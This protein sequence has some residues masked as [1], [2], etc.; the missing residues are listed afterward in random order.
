MNNHP[1]SRPAL[2]LPDAVSLVVGI[3]I[4]SGIYLTPAG[5]FANVASAGAGLLVWLAGGVV[6]LVGALCYAELATAYPTASGEYAYLRRAYGPFVGFSFAWAQLAVIRTGASLAPV[7]YVFAT[8]AQQLYDLGPNSKLIYVTAAIVGLTLVNAL[9]IHPGRRTQNL[10]TL[11]KLMGLCGLVLAGLWLYVRP[12]RMVLIEQ[13]PPAANT[14]LTLA[15]VLVLWTYSGWHEVAYVVMDLRDRSR[16]LTRAIL[17]GVAAVT[18]VYLA[19]NLAL[20]AGLGFTGVRE[21]KAVASDLLERAL[22]PPGKA[23]MAWLVVI[24]TLGATNGLILAGGR[25]FAGFGELHPGFGWLGAGRTNR[26]APLVAL[27][28]QAAVSLGMVALV[29]CGDAWR[30]WVAE[31]AQR[32][33]VE[34]PLDLTAPTDG[35][36]T[37]V[38]CTG[39]VFWFFLLLTGGALLVLRV[40]DAD[41]PRPFRV[42]LFPVVSVLF[43]GA[44]LFMLYQSGAYAASQRPAEALVVA[45]LFVLGLP[46]YALTRRGSDGEG[47]EDERES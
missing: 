42:P 40:K 24:S 3:I 4:G 23:A 35:F 27:A 32:V 34:L 13:A 15:L 46:V 21:S 38:V 22:G 28:A 20:L 25:F 29:E 5:V 12:T 9:G 17:L 19:V 8:Y 6:A 26:G 37:L 36:T 7:A 10:L 43:C 41:H 31:A 1:H 18:A 16:N 39:P 2:G 30:A 14:S 44:S 47:G 45:A 11:A 33:G